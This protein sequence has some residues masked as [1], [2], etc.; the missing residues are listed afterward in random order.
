M[1]TQM[2]TQL[3]PSSSDRWGTRVGLRYAVYGYPHAFSGMV[4]AHTLVHNHNE[5]Q[6]RPLISN[7][8]GEAIGIDPF[9]LRS[10]SRQ[11]IDIPDDTRQTFHALAAVSPAYTLHVTSRI[12]VNKTQLT[13]QLTY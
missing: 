12:F 9:S 4:C 7:A 11:S 10:I 8:D 1:K 6:L 3:V 5:L 2:S 13:Q